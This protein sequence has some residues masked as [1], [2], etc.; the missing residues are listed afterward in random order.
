VLVLEQIPRN[1]EG[2]LVRAELA[3]MINLSLAATA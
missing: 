2:K 3:A 1:H